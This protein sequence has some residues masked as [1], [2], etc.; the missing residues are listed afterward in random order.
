MKRF[1]KILAFALAAVT[2]GSTVAPAI[3][4]PKSEIAAKAVTFTA[5]L[6]DMMVET[7]G[8]PT[9]IRSGPSKS[10][11]KVA[12]VDKGKKYKYLGETYEN[13]AKSGDRIWY[14]IQYSSNKVAYVT[15]EFSKKV[16]P[17][18]VVTCTGNSVNVRPD[19]TGLK[20]PYGM[21]NKGDSF[22]ATGTSSNGFV[23]IVYKNPKTGK[24]V[25][26]WIS[27]KY[28]TSKYY[29]RRIQ[30]TGDPVN[31]REG[32]GTSYAKLRETPAHKGDIFIYLR[33]A[34]DKYG[35]IWYYT[36]TYWIT[37]DLAV[38]KFGA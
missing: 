26:A 30:I 36:G 7:T 21:V 2:L 3:V 1:T 10:T 38:T 35:T 17:R 31:L 16:E 28:V 13:N 24:T 29:T 20:A 22:Y 14:K 12:S 19:Y 4:Q 9:V 25:N 18:A 11:S 8:Q 6:E 27:Q 32:P 37:S 23:Q 34:K 15:S 5:K 33:E